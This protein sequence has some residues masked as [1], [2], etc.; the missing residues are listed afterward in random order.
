MTDKKSGLVVTNADTNMRVSPWSLSGSMCI[1]KG[2]PGQN[3]A[4]LPPVNKGQPG[5]IR[6]KISVSLAK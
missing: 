6:K 5:H 1:M 3:V 4:V 2:Y